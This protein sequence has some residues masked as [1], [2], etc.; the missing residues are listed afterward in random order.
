[1]FSNGLFFLENLNELNVMSLSL[2]ILGF[3]EEIKIKRVP[4]LAQF[5]DGEFWKLSNGILT[6]LRQ[7]MIF[8]IDHLQP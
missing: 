7:L 6:I 5:Y 8:T 1:M 3:G 2:Q 4:F